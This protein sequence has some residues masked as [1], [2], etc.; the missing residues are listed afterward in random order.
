MVQ[1]EGGE[2]TTVEDA[3]FR[4]ALSSVRELAAEIALRVGVATRGPSLESIHV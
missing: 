4:H 1:K 2:R 3:L